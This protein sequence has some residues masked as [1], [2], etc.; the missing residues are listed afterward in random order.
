M[1]LKL[2]NALIPRNLNF[3]IIEDLEMI[4]ELIIDELDLLGFEGPF[5]QAESLKSSR[6]EF[7]KKKPDIILLDWTLDDGTGDIF[8]EAL[9]KNKSFDNIPV[10]MIT[11][12]DNVEDLIHAL[13]IGASEYLIKPW[14]TEEFTEKLSSA[15]LKHFPEKLVIEGLELA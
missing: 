13:N 15:W 1:M 10:M 2:D 12:N 4:R 8:L 5:A 6:I 7:K 14:T 9:R 3:L 11:S